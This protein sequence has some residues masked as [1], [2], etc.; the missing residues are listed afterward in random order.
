[1]LSIIQ[2]AGWQIWPLIACS[3]YAYGSQLEGRR[4]QNLRE[5]LVGFDKEDGTLPIKADA[6]ASHQAVINVLEAASFNG[7]TKIAFATQ[8]AI[9][10]KLAKP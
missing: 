5:A 9:P 7:I 4:T 1:M 8:Q 3:V 10:A 2:A 6:S